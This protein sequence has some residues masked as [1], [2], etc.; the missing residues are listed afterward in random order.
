APFLRP[1]VPR[2]VRAGR[3]CAPQSGDRRTLFVS[4]QL[5]GFET[6]RMAIYA[7]FDSEAGS[8]PRRCP[9]GPYARLLRRS[10]A[11]GV[12]ALEQG[13]LPCAVG[14][15]SAGAAIGVRSGGRGIASLC[16]G[17][18]SADADR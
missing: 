16:W 17:E 7:L 11:D 6:E 4:C 3:G 2:A 8:P 12:A 10:V 5:G 18:G 13:G 9:K 14:V 15:W 1:A